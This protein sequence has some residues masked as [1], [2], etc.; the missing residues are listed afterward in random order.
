MLCDVCSKEQRKA[1]R[2]VCASVE[3]V[4][5]GSSRDKV[6]KGR[7][8]CDCTEETSPLCFVQ[9]IVTRAIMRM[10]SLKD[11]FVDMPEVV[12]EDLAML[13]RFGDS[14]GALLFDV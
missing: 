2:I 6:V 7:T 4:E 13:C 5:V 10:L 14:R 12:V 11:N 9:R 8:C 1:C 3:L